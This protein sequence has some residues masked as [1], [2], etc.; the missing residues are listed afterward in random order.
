MEN[1]IHCSEWKIKHVD[2]NLEK[3]K[4]SGYTAVLVGPVQ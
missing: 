2:D 4:E 3:I 1:I